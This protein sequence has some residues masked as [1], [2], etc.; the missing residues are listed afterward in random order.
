MTDYSQEEN[1]VAATSIFKMKI[2]QTMERIKEENFQDT[3]EA[4]MIFEE[5]VYEEY[6]EIQMEDLEQAPYKF[7]DTQPQVHDPMKEVNL[8]TVE[9][10]RITY[11]SSLLPSDLKEEIIAILQEFKECFG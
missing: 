8:N 11:I 9:E 3:Y 1:T 2:Q 10:P 5:D 7:E 4:E 6:E